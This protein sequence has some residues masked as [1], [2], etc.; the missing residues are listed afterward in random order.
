MK[1][2]DIVISILCLIFFS[3]L[4]LMLYGQIHIARGGKLFNSRITIYKLYHLMFLGCPLMSS[5]IIKIFLYYNTQNYAHTFIIIFFISLFIGMIISSTLFLYDRKLLC[6][7]SRKSHTY[8]FPVRR[9][10]LI[11]SCFTACMGFSAILIW[12]LMFIV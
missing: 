8:D 10:F 1:T 12:S 2:I 11:I 5:V 7:L 3:G 4:A 6:K 9:Q